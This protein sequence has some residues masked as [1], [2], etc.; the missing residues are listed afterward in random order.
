MIIICVRDDPEVKK[1]YNSNYSSNC[2]AYRA[3]DRHY[4]LYCHI[5]HLQ[6]EKGVRL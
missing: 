4:H 5:H 6:E 3:N 2:A 1:F